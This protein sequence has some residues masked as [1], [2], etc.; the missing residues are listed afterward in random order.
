MTGMVGV[1][2]KGSVGG[3]VGRVVVGCS[4]TGGKDGVGVGGRVTGDEEGRVVGGRV[5]GDSVG[6]IVVGTGEREGGCVEGVSIT[7][8]Y[9]LNSC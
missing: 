2:V 6:G 7:Y 3:S 9:V 4:V 5:V 1:G 8:K